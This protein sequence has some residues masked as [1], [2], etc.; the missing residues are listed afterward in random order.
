MKL[1]FFLSVLA[2]AAVISSCKENNA[3]PATATETNKWIY[4][5]MKYWYYW[6]DRIPQ[7]PDYAKSAS[8]FFNSLLYKY[9]PA[10]RPDGDRFS[11]MQ[12]SAKELEASLG[13]ESKTTG[14]EYKLVHFPANTTNVI[15]I[16]LYVIPGSPAAK[17]G[18]A[19]GDVFSSVNGQKMTDANYSKLLNTQ[20]KATYTLARIQDGTLEETTT[21]RDVT[22]EVLQED[23][24]FFDSVYTIGASKIG[25][26]VYHQFIPEPFQAN[27]KA[28][29]KKLDAIFADFKNNNV[30]ALVLDFRYNPGGY[31][32]SATNL[33]SLIGKVNANDIFYYKEYNKQVT[34]TSLKKYGESYFYDKFIAKSQNIGGNLQQLVVLVSGRTASASELV[35]NGL[36]PFMPVTL[37]GSRTVGKNVGSITISDEKNGI[38]VGLQPI[39]SKSLNKDKKSDYHVGFEPD[40]KASEGNV[41]YPYGDPRDPLLGEALFQITGTHVTRQGRNARVLQEEESAELSSTIERKAGGSNMFFDR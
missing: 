38:Q 35:I 9:D 24:V 22:P 19:R 21:R 15:G 7:S 2:L 11:W 32:S 17:A 14:M 40:V 20:G 12:E 16:V 28:Y 18:F 3:D 8:D 37:I 5:N 30:N 26:V 36:K 33:A 39:V 31:V 4:A 25:Y 41:L 23:P 34:E 27:N 1:R 6:T 13:G 29:D 10:A